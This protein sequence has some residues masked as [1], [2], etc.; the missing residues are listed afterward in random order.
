M[1][2][3]NSFLAAGPRPPCGRQ[4]ARTECAVLA[5]NRRRNRL[6]IVTR[7]A[8]APRPH[9]SHLTEPP[10]VIWSSHWSAPLRLCLPSVH[11][12]LSPPAQLRRCLAHNEPK[13][14][15]QKFT[16]PSLASHPHW[17]LFLHALSRPS[18][19]PIGGPRVLPPGSSAFVLFFLCVAVLR[20]SSG[21]GDRSAPPRSSSSARREAPAPPLCQCS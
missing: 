16:A 12:V 18:C 1:G 9:L 10:R 8:L 11:T 2:Q 7:A 6:Q 13:I 4:R 21:I 15:L 19:F 5:V 17:A 20:P 3:Q 14:M